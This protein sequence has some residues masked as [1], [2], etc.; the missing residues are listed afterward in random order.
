MLSNHATLAFNVNQINAVRSPTDTLFHGAE[1]RGCPL[2]GNQVVGVL[3]TEC[4]IPPYSLPEGGV[5]WSLCATTLIS[6]WAAA[7]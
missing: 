6:E 1:T 2:F 3:D 4:L 5:F 7:N